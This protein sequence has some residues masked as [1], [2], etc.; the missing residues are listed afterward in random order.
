MRDTL[1]GS[2]A[3]SGLIQVANYITD[4][5]MLRL[6][7]MQGADRILFGSDCPWDDPANEINLINRLPLTE[8]EREKIFFRNAEGLLGIGG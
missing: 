3:I 7:K 5:T 6:I 2:S 8:E 4:E 1:P